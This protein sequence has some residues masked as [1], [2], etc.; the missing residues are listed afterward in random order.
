MCDVKEDRDRAYN[1]AVKASEIRLKAGARLGELLARE[2]QH[3]GGRPRKPLCSICSTLQ[4][5]LFITS[6]SNGKLMVSLP[7]C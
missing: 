6:L 7:S 1:V 2:I 3:Q 4:T 5:Y